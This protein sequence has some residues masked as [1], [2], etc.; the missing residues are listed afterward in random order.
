MIN[1]LNDFETLKEVFEMAEVLT[2]EYQD[3]LELQTY[4]DSTGRF[5]RVVFKFNDDFE[6]TEVVSEDE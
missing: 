4:N 1:E 6:L 5:N 3:R 2:A